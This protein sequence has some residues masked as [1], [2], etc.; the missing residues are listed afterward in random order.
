MIHH[1]DLWNQVIERVPKNATEV[2]ILSGYVGPS[3]INALHKKPNL[4][5]TIIF[6]LFKE[7]RKKALHD[8][9]VRLNYGNVQIL[10]PD[11]PAH[12]KCY[13][14][15]NSSGE[16]V[17]AMIGSANFSSNGLSIPYRESLLET[18]DDDMTR[19]NNYINLIMKT[20]R[21]CEK[22]SE[23]ELQSNT[24]KYVIGPDTEEF[25]EGVAKLNLL[26]RRGELPTSSGINW[27]MAEGSH[28]TI[29][30]AYIPIRKEAIRNHPDLFLPRIILPENVQ[31]RGNIDEVVELI[32]DDGE[33]MQVK[34]EGK[35]DIE[36]DSGVKIKYPKQIS[37]FP[38]K[39]IMGKYLRKRIGVPSGVVVK[40]EDLMRYGSTTILLKK[41]SEGVYS[42]N[43]SPN[44][45]EPKIVC[46]GSK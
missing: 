1:D 13:V 7:N 22:V 39:A 27:G 44:N 29:D 8:E 42:A 32:W 3:P 30:D 28:V 36:N 21:S 16:P 15:L 23:K 35:Q 19:I 11:L 45:N 33:I 31:A 10:Y 14:W 6:G 37:S 25:E 38:N 41:L 4:K 43:F 9:L 5:C 18:Y 26:D 2:K 40:K 12:S 46:I 17:R 20:C 34:F 24:P